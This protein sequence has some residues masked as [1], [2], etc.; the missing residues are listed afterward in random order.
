[1]TKFSK[2]EAARREELRALRAIA[3][4]NG[5]LDA[6]RAECAFFGWDEENPLKLAH[7]LIASAQIRFSGFTEKATAV[8]EEVWAAFPAAHLAFITR[9]QASLDAVAA[10][11]FG[12]FDVVGFI[13][14]DDP[15]FHRLAVR[16]RC[17][18]CGHREERK[19]DFLRY[20]AGFLACPRCGARG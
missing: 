20:G 7:A 16:L 8:A 19:L 5:L 15:D 10:E 2:F 12:A 11:S 14:E 6:A 1:M 4:R 18:R 3:K 17:R 9:R 13:N